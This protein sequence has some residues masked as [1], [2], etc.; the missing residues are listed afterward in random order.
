MVAA[1]VT[2]ASRIRRL[3]PQLIP[4]HEIHPSLRT[5][6]ERLNHRL[7][8]FRRKSV[9]LKHPVHFRLLLF[10]HF[11]DLAL[12]PNTFLLV[13]F[14]VSTRCQISTQS[15]GNRS[16]SNFRQS[17]HHDQ[18]GVLHRTGKSGCQ[19][20]RHSQAV[21]HANHHVAHKQSGSKMFF[22]MWSTRHCVKPPE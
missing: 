13:M 10:R 7:A 2:G 22:N 17:S 19:G 9:G 12:F 18:L 5:M 20:K 14:R 6:A 1:L 8:L 4:H 11:F 3:Q 16:G 21:S 15:H